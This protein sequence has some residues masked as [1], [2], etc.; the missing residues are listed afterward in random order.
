MI[1]GQVERQSS[2]YRQGLVLGLTMAEIMLL[3]VFCLLLAT[4]VALHYE[5]E[6]RT[7]A[8]TQLLQIIGADEGGGRRSEAQRVLRDAEAYRNLTE[9]LKQLPPLDQLAEHNPTPARQKEIDEAWRRLVEGAEVA[10]ELSRAG[11][12]E[13]TAK[14][15]T[16]LFAEAERIKKEGLDLKKLREEA[17]FARTLKNLLTES[18]ITAKT[19][20][21]IVELARAGIAAGPTNEGHKWPPIISL[22]EAGGYYFEVG[23][24]ELSEDF[25]VALTNKMVPRILGIAAQYPDVNIIEVVGHTDKQ[26]IRKRYSNM[27]DGILDSLKSGDV[28]SLI[29][30]DN[31]GLG[32]ARA[33]A[34]V[35][36]LL[37]DERLQRFSR[38]LPLSGAQLIQIDETLTRGAE[39]DVKERRRIEI[40]LRKHEGS[41]P[42]TARKN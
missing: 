22:S 9:R 21:D 37:Q 32:L 16:E 41:A 24:A 11:I 29:P 36:R 5:R 39:G 35:T 26:H 33:V 23:S 38:I 1:G 40:R 4:S 7:A 15:D 28:A 34:V 31:A 8:E 13:A 12:D 6:Q 3:L 27:D 20:S 2:S 14:R 30:A 25:K 18:K 19:P 17:Q 10:R 42:D